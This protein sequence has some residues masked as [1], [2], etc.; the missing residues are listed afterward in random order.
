MRQFL[1]KRIPM[2]ILLLCS[3]SYSQMLFSQRN[4]SGKVSDS[5]GSSLVGVNVLVVGSTLATITDLD[6]NFTISVPS[7]NAKLQFSFIG[8]ITETV[9]VGNQS[10]ISVVLVEDLVALNEVVVI[11]Y[12]SMR[13]SDLT[14]AISSISPKELKNIPVRS[15][16]DALQGKVAGVS[17][18]S[19]SGSPGSL[20]A[21]NIRGIASVNGTEPIYVVDGFPQGDISW[22]NSNDIESMEVLKDASACAIYGSRGANGVIIVTS[23]QGKKGK[24]NITYDGFYGTQT[25]INKPALMTGGEFYAFKKSRLNI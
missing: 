2:I 6:G 11:G 10:K 1:R 4:I 23:K 18:S 20:P 5:N 24:L 12:G 13:K 14:G 19:T 17:I 9:D 16:T 15:A 25:I 3:V 8:F 7:D 21:V 22:L